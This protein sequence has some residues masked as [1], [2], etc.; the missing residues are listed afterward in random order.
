MKGRC[1]RLKEGKALSDLYPEVAREWHPKKNGTIT[2]DKV[3]AKSSKKVWWYLPYDDPISGKHFEFEWAEHIN[4]R[5]DK[6]YGCPYLSGQAVWPGFNDLA[7]RAPKIAS[8]WHPTKNGKLTPDKVTVSSRKKVWWYFPYDDPISGKHFKFEWPASIQH[9]TGKSSGCPFLSGQ[10]VWPGFNDLAS[11]FPE[12]ANQW[13]PTKNGELTPDKVAAK[14]NKEVWWY[15]PYDDPIS[16]KH[17]EFEWL[18]KVSTRTHLGRG[19]P[20]LS[21]RAVWSG[22]N[23]LASQFPEIANQWHPTKNGELTPD[24][25]AAKSNKEVWWYL[26]YD[27]PISKKHFEFEWI[28]RIKD[29]TTKKKGC[30][31]LSGQAVW[32]G[33]N[34]LASQFPAIANQWHPTKNGGLTPDRVTAGSGKKVWWYLPYD[35]P[36]SGKHF[37]F[38][39]MEYIVTRTNIGTGCPFLSGK[40]VW[41]GFNDL[42]SQF[43]EIAGQWHPTKN[44]MLTPDKVA[45]KSSKKIWWY[46]PYDDPISGKHFDFEWFVSVSAR[47]AKGGGCPYLSGQAVWPGFNDLESQFPEI[48]SQWHPT[49]NGT[50]TPDKITATSGKKVWW[51]L[52]YDD[53]VSGKHFD[54]EWPAKVYNRTLDKNGCPYLSGQAV[55]PGFN[56]LESQFPEIALELHPTKNHHINPSKIAAFSNKK[57]WWSCKMCKKE[58]FMRI[59]LRTGMGVGCPECSKNS[60]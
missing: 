52:S 26:P 47:T 40:A 28:A 49:K 5:T 31:Y 34:D 43:P 56:D 38:E 25:V 27:D 13:H 11:Q 6:G 23:D 8:Q 32:S 20:Y 22:F 29:R 39:W 53:P 15:L 35:D 2:P 7:S 18:T 42:E 50:L 54:F 10:A 59:Y 41:P 45:A 16:E 17:F 1:F 33:F 19:C 3:A 21:G 48:A 46:L 9:R 36:I 55:W 44:G 58:W 14:S 24:K 60:Y 30:P 57:V 37:E 51:Y 12:I 4:N